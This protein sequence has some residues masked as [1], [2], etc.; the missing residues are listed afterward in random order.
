MTVPTITSNKSTGIEVLLYRNSVYE[1]ALLGIDYTYKY[2]S[3]T[4]IQVQFFTAG[5]YIANYGF[6]NVGSWILEWQ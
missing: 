4:Q 3:A 5:T 1:S 6:Y 2:T